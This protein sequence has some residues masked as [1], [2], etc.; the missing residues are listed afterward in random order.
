MSWH[1]LILILI[2]LA[3]ATP[4]GIARQSWRRLLT[5][6]AL[7]FLVVV[8]P[9]FAYFASSVLI[10]DLRWKGAC[11]FGWVDCFI[12]SKLAF[13]PFVLVATA[14]LYR[15]EVLQDKKNHDRWLVLGIYLGAIISV[16]CFIFGVVCAPYYPWLLVPLYVA[17]W[18]VTRAVQLIRRSAWPFGDY[19][20]ATLATIPSWITAWFWAKQTYVALPETPPSGCFVVT[21]AGRGH[22]NLVGPFLEIEHRGQARRAN[23]QLVTLWRFENSWREKFPRS[24]QNFRRLYN[25]IGPVIAARIRSPWLADVIFLALKPAEWFAKICLKQARVK[26]S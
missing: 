10:M 18:Y 11:R 3:L 5:A 4:E 20:L 1:L 9:L 6:M 2:L 26:A 23:L 19:L 22:S 17:A 21:A 13:A 15:I 16:T 25:R 24:H 7:S 8:L 14:A 12:L